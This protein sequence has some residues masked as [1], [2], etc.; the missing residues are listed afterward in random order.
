MTPEAGKKVKA[1][2]E[3][4]EERDG[5]ADKEDR[6]ENDHFDK[7]KALNQKRTLKNHQKAD[8]KTRKITF[9]NSI[10]KDSKPDGEAKTQV[11]QANSMMDELPKEC[12]YCLAKRLYIATNAKLKSKE[13]ISSRFS[14]LDSQTE[15]SQKA[16]FLTVSF[17][18]ENPKRRVYTDE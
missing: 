18:K 2:K 5:S 11:K 9:N 3:A 17:S 10:P 16:K 8:Q 13:S 6:Q 4:L 12:I 7:S 15:K 1:S 14:R